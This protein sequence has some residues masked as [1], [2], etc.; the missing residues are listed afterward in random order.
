MSVCRRVI[1][2]FFI[3]TAFAASDAYAKD[4]ALILSGG[5]ARG[6]SQIGVLK[7]LDEAGIKPRL[8]VAASM[9]SIVGSLYAAGY[10]PDS[11]Y[12]F[13]KSID[14]N[15][16]FS[17]TSQ[18]EQLLVSQKNENLNYLLEL[19]FDKHFK[20]VW[21][22]ALSYGQAFYQYLV[23]KLAVAQYRASE[24]FDSLDIPLRIVATDIIA[25]RMV[26]FSKGDIVS[27]VRAS[28]G[29]PLIFSPVEYNG[30][31][32]MDGG[33]SANIPVEPVIE[34]NSGYYI[35]A[36]DA[37]SSLWSKEELNSPVRLVDQL[38]AIGISKQKAIE[39][40]LAQTVITPKLEH[41]KSTDFS[42]IDS[43]VA[44]GY[45][46]AKNEIDKIK[47]DISSDSATKAAAARN[48][49]F[50]CAPFRWNSIDI[51]LCG[52]LDSFSLRTWGRG[53][54]V[55]RD[56]I[57][58]KVCFFLKH[59]GY[60][61]A[62][63][64]SILRGGDY[65]VDIAVEPGRIKNIVIEGNEVT[66]PNL[67][68]AAIPLKVWDVL[69]ESRISKTI[70]SLYALGLFKNVNVAMDS[71]QTLH[72]KVEEMEFWRMK[73][74]MRYD[75]FHLGEGY[76]Q[77]AY[78]NLFGSGLSAILH[79]QYGLRREQ[80]SFE[81]TN[82][83][84]FSPAIAQKLQLKCYISREII[85]KESES[86]DTT[87]TTGILYKTTIDEQSLRKAGIMFVAGVQIGRFAM[88]DGGIRIERF[89]RTLSEQSVFND[90]YKDFEQGVPYFLL[91]TTIDNLDKYPF[92]EKGQK[93]YISM[94]GANKN[95]GASES[96]FKI[97]ASSSQYYTIARR[98]TFSP[99]L[100]FLWASD[101]LPDAERA[102]VGG[103]MPEENYS[104]TCVYNYMPFFGLAQ[105]ALSGDIALLLRGNYRF[106]LKQ[107]L[108][109]TLTFDWGYAW[110]WNRQWAWDTRGFS[111][112]KNIYSEFIDKAPV[113]IGV[114][115]AYNSLI[116][117]IRFSWGR[118]LR[119]RFASELNIK[120][121]NQLYLSIGHDF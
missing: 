5:G 119:N 29:L 30:T 22:N 105:R 13:V 62:R 116:G 11:I 92:P 94:G 69:T 87:D 65:P 83:N 9:G 100:K 28:S 85:R 114:G 34:E 72:I 66:S 78:V 67:I 37:T 73:A 63:I 8:I 107:K 16:V 59:K 3:F 58:S 99:Q 42:K 108:Y 41:Y 74:G 120:S 82:N 77:P 121:G 39:R 93:H 27:A 32:L 38:V 112:A 54:T 89:R 2:L 115:I 35:I 43:I 17:N 61:F 113:G 53:D 24:S 7:A 75:E 23:P 98:H 21:P 71:S 68:L 60:P 102:Y 12:S 51:G 33:M 20:I 19:H 15:D 70:N 46:A 56:S 10:S 84:I 18:R 1:I 50:F 91:R 101:S 111:T 86:R 44:R 4:V 104:E 40:A 52:L 6:F 110:T 55:S 106:M 97:E 48:D 109:F 103:A 90:P 96:F 64:T 95:I 14:W 25:G 47:N 88:L 79:L 36:V 57:D 76:V 45:A 80:Y 49:D 118:L 117:P 26:V 81:L 31:L